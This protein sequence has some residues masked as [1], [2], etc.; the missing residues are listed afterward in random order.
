[1][2]LN[3]CY[4][5]LYHL[6]YAELNPMTSN[7]KPASHSQQNKNVEMPDNLFDLGPVQPSVCKLMED[8]WTFIPISYLSQCSWLSF[9]GNNSL[10]LTVNC[11]PGFKGSHLLLSNILSH[12]AL[13]IFYYFCLCFS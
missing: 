1:M 10:I 3:S 13:S 5:A 6:S 12:L 4:L 7:S 2:A 8:A 9:P 11:C